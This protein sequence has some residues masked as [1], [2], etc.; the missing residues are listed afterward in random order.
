[1][2]CNTDD[3]EAGETRLIS[4][5][6]SSYGVKLRWSKRKQSIDDCW[7]G[8]TPREIGFVG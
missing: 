7:R 8:E 3:S 6:E 5:A 4:E 1:W 2:F